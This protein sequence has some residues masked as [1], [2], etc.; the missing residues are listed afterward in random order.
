MN[1]SSD[2]ITVTVTEIGPPI[3]A[4]HRNQR[5]RVTAHDSA[6]RNLVF[7]VVGASLHLEIG[8]QVDL[9]RNECG[10]FT[11]TERD[12]LKVR[13]LRSTRQRKTRARAGALAT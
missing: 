3:P 8:Q 13:T 10:V 9:T 7:W 11:L 6:V 2:N 4:A 5:W 12:K 1:E